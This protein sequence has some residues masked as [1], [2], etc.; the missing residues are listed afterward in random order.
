MPN[1]TFLGI[2]SHEISFGEK[3]ITHPDTQHISPSVIDLSCPLFAILGMRLSRFNKVYFLT[4][5]FCTAP[6]TGALWLHSYT[7]R[8]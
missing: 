7:Y 4:K 5:L 1:L 8:T 6:A 2:L 3:T